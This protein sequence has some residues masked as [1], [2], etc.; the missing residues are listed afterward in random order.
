[1]II[2]VLRKPFNGTLVANI[3]QHGC[4]G[5][6]IDSSRIDYRSDQDQTPEVRGR[7]TGALNEGS[8]DSFP[9][10]K[11][12]WGVWVA[13]QGRF[14]ANLI[15]QDSPDVLACFP[16]TKSGKETEGGHKRNADKF[17]Q[18]GCYGSF[19]GAPTE[20]GVLYGDEGSASR[21]F[22]VLPVRGT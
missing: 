10:H 4:G 12:N 11:K 13:K 5:V 7:G 20:D 17:A 6:N 2:T 9:Q 15:L 1:M 3:L 18:R 21:F 22:R 19:A 14:P 8:G 16:S